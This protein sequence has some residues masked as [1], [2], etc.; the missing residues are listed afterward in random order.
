MTSSPPPEETLAEQVQRLFT[1]PQ[2]LCKQQGLCCRVA[3]FKGLASHQELLT[4]AH[5]PS[6][7]DPELQAMARDFASIF[8][9]HPSHAEAH[10]LA[11]HFVEEVKARAAT[12]SQPPEAVTF[13]HCRYVQEDNRCGV[14]ED[15]PSGCRA[16][17]IPH[18]RSL[19]HKGCGYEA[20][21]KQQLAELKNLLEPYG[22]AENL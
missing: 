17:P 2:H 18:S 4:L 3:V 11:P 1:L 19:F 21:A 15:R 7:A 13:Y 16:Y 14:H 9:P 20:Q 6:P 8:I 12:Q 5:D 22:L 10:A